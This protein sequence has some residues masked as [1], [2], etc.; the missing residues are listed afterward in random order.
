MLAQRRRDDTVDTTGGQDV[1]P[2][3]DELPEWLQEAI[4]AAE[5]EVADEMRALGYDDVTVTWCDDDVVDR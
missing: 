1:T 2:R 4:A 3:R 5:Q